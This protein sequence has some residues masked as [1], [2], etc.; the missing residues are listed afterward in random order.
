MKK[1]IKSTKRKQK[2]SSSKS[3]DSK[4]S[5]PNPVGRP[6]I[7]SSPDE[8]QE[9]VNSYVESCVKSVKPMTLTG[10]IIALGLSSRESLDLYAERKEFKEVVSRA[11]LFIEYAYELR[12][13]GSKPTG[14]IFALKNFNWKDRQEVDHSGKI[15][16]GPTFI[17]N[18][19]G[20]KV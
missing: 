12:L 14:A 9:L 15:A 2:N 20:V 13:H 1:I 3:K 18:T 6:R 11:K 10:M 4:P 7:I 8:M 19:S 5:N 17:V 16:T